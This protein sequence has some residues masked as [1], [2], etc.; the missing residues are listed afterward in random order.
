M[1][2]LIDKYTLRDKKMEKP[3]KE[4]LK[5]VHLTKNTGLEREVGEIDFLKIPCDE[6]IKVL[7]N[8]EMI[9]LKREQNNK[10]ANSLCSLTSEMFAF[11]KA[12]KENFD[13]DTYCEH[14]ELFELLK[15]YLVVIKDTK[16]Y[17]S[18]AKI[19]NL[20]F[21]LKYTDYDGYEYDTF[22]EHSHYNVSQ[23]DIDHDYVGDYELVLWRPLPMKLISAMKN[24]VAGLAGIKSKRTFDDFDSK[25]SNEEIDEL[26]MQL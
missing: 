10:N 2:V 19:L 16:K 22:D 1:K 11:D 20:T 21:K 18:F 9:R 14:D 8:V 3:S 26:S 12:L 13:I 25:H 24:E 5:N 4:Y 17:E 23:K 15:K 6:L 7:S